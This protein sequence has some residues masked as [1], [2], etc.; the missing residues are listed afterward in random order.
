MDCIEKERSAYLGFEINRSQ[1][2]LIIGRH[3]F[4]EGRLKR[5]GLFNPH[6]ISE[7]EARSTC[8]RSSDVDEVRCEGVEMFGGFGPEEGEKLMSSGTLRA[9]SNDA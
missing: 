8:G 2:G 7:R 4:F 5:K 6:T 1:S 9:S 3:D